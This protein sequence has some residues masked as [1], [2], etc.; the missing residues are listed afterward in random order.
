MPKD[1]HSYAEVK[2]ACDIFT[3]ESS[4]NFQITQLYNKKL[5][6]M[7]NQI[8][9]FHEC[10]RKSLTSKAALREFVLI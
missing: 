7:I 4:I 5:T 2:D 1:D 10:S 6:N 8:S 3:K 9:P